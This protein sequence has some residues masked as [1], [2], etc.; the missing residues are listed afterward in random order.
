MKQC[1]VKEGRTAMAFRLL[2]NFG[3]VPAVWIQQEN[4]STLPIFHRQTNFH[5]LVNSWKLLCT[6]WTSGKELVKTH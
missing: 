3:F 5:R 4:T 1:G 2:I 6:Q